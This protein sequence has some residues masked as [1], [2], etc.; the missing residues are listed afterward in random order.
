MRREVVLADESLNALDCECLM[1][2]GAV[3]AASLAPTCC[4]TGHI[5]APV[6]LTVRDTRR[7]LRLVLLT[8]PAL[9][10][11]PHDTKKLRKC[12]EGTKH[13]HLKE[14][15]LQTDRI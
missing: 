3:T 9:S 6:T 11:T 7:F 10:A 14:T 4:G 5:H 1:E 13:F 2:A 12:E 15:S 8:Q